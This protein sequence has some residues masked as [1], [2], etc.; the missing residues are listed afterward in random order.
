MLAQDSDGKVNEKVVTIEESVELLKSDNDVYKSTLDIPSNL[1]IQGVKD[2]KPLG[3]SINCNIQEIKE[4]KSL[5]MFSLA[6]VPINF[7]SPAKAEKVFQI[8]GS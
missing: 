2:I 5:G 3:H 1:N 4:I 6:S 8:N 7:L